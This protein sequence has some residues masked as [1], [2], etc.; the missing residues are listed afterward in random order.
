M[1]GAINILARTMRKSSSVCLALAVLLAGNACCFCAACCFAL[2]ASARRFCSACFFASASAAFFALAW[3]TRFCSASCLAFTSACCFAFA[4]A[5]FFALASASCFALA[6]ACLAVALLLA[7]V[8]DLAVLA[9]NL[10]RVLGLRH[11]YLVFLPGVVLH[12][13]LAISLAD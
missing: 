4:L 8:L 6:A 5:A 12:L 3:A 7:G 1:V 2:A 9:G 13:E 10:N 11:H